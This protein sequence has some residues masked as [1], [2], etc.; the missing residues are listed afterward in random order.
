MFFYELHSHT[1]AASLCSIVEPEDF[2]KFYIDKGFPVH[3][4]CADN[5]ADVTL[6]IERGAC[7][8]TANDPIPL[9]KKLGRL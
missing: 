4:Y 5:D 6:C 9:M 1:N 2:I 8:I 7:L 3:M